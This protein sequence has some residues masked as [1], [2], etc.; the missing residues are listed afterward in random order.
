M[1][2]NFATNSAAAV[3]GAPDD[4]ITGGAGTYAHTQLDASREF[5]TRIP[6]DTSQ[7]CSYWYDSAPSGGSF[8]IDV[9]GYRFDR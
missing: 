6:L 8:N 5:A 9:L 4:G 3:V 2:L 1:L 7:Q